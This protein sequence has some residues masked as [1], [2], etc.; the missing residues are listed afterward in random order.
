MVLVDNTEMQSILDLLPAT[1]ATTTG[2]SSANA[3]L[4]ATRL[5]LRTTFLG[6]LGHD[7]HATAYRQRFA[8]AGVDISRFKQAEQ[9]TARCLALVTPDA[10]RTLRTCLAA[11]MTLSPSEISVADFRGCRHAHI[12]GYLAFNR[13]LADAVLAT[14]RSAGCSISFD[15]SS[16][17]VVAATRS[18]LHEQFQLGLDIVF[19]N[20]DEIRTLFETTTDDFAALARKLAGYGTLAVV[21]LGKDGA[22]LARADELHRVEPVSVSKVVDTNGAGDAFAGGFLAGH[23]R[24]LPMPACGRLAALLGAETVRH[25]GPLIPEKDWPDVAAQAARIG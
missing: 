6:K 19:G 14:A 4:N 2:G 15:L 7:A 11:A 22:W 3:T 21:K 18:W 1:P 13:E 10:Q 16:F 5:G 17:E 9:P 8:A 25:L 12:E 23:L 24:G 20:E